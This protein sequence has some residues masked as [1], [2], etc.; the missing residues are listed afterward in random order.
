MPNDAFVHAIRRRYVDDGASVRIFSFGFV[1]ALGSMRIPRSLSVS[2]IL[3]GML[4]VLSTGL[5]HATFS[6]LEVKRCSRC[7]VIISSF[8]GRLSNFG[9]TNAADVHWTGLWSFD[10]S[11]KVK[12]LLCHISEIKRFECDFKRPSLLVLACRIRQLPVRIFNPKRGIRLP[13]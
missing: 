8:E 13:T 1:F 5:N 11:M 4:S 2:L 12:Y 6:Y 7:A 10:R 3:C 9:L